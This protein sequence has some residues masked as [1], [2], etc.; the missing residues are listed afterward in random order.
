VIGVDGGGPVQGNRRIWAQPVLPL[1]A[2][3]RGWAL[4]MA[5]LVSAFVVAFILGGMLTGYNRLI[6]WVMGPIVATLAGG[7]FIR[8]RLSVPREL[9]YQALLLVWALI[10][11]A[12]A[13]HMPSFVRMYR[14]LFEVFVLSFMVIVA[15]GRQDAFRVM[16]WGI[17]IAAT[18][19]FIGY[20]ITGQMVSQ[21]DSALWAGG[22][23][24][25]GD[26]NAVGCIAAAGIMAAAVL[27]GTNRGF[28]KR[29]L[30]V[31]PMPLLLKG[32]VIAGSRSAFL[33]ALAFV[34]GWVLWART[35][36]RVLRTSHLFVSVALVLTVFGGVRFVAQKTYLGERFQKFETAGAMVTKNSRASLYGEAWR[37]WERSP[38]WGVGLAQFTV[39]SESRLM[40]HSDIAELLGTTG[41]VGLGLYLS[42]Y[43]V[44]LRR[45][46]FLL[47]VARGQEF[48]VRVRVLTLM[49]GLSFIG[50][51]GRTNF[52]DPLAVILYATVIA[53]SHRLERLLVGRR[54]PVP[55]FS[56]RQREGLGRGTGLTPGFQSGN[57][58]QTQSL[59]CMGIGESQ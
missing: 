13:V 5:I 17:L 45:L 35:G 9:L 27:W 46:R 30:V 38:I 14:L 50:G 37:I 54:R 32:L 59:D 10:G 16:M 51:M 8:L 23:L 22:R 26:A 4:F 36:G 25:G 21:T 55:E 41:A 44:S 6:L 15:L 28:V 48:T 52:V 12:V 58:L 43:V 31:L 42:M 34:L 29:F 49:L 47:R 19:L 53:E 11:L 2:P 40:G 39:Y 18:G 7:T 20:E 1:G 56:S 57:G 3:A 24:G 33:L